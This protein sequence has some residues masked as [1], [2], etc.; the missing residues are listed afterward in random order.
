MA[1]IT[2]NEISKNYSYSVGTSS[3]ATVAMPITASWGPGYFNPDD[4]S[5]ECKEVDID[6]DW[7]IEN[8]SDMLDRTVWQRFPA[9]QAGLESFVSTYRG[10][11]PNFRL[12]QD[13]SYQMAITLLT[14]G[15]DVLVC[16]LSPGARAESQFVYRNN[17]QG[18][19]ECDAKVT[20]KAKYPG[21]FGNNLRV[22]I[23]NVGFNSVDANG[24]H[25]FS[26][27][28]NMLVYIVDGSGI[29]TPVENK[30]FVFDINNADDNLQHWREVESNYVTLSVTGN[31]IDFTST[32]ETDKH[33]KIIEKR[34]GVKLIDGSDNNRNST[35]E[36]LSQTK[37]F[38]V[39]DGGTD[40]NEAIEDGLTN[41]DSIKEKLI[42]E[43][44]KWANKRYRP[45]ADG[46]IEYINTGFKYAEIERNYLL[47]FD[48]LLGNADDVVQSVAEY[49][50]IPES[51]PRYATLKK[52]IGSTDTI[53]EMDL[54]KARVIHFREWI[55]THLVGLM[56]RD[57][58]YEGVY[59]LLKD[60]LAYNPNRIIASGWDDQD[61]CYM[62]G[63][64]D[65]NILCQQA[66][67]LRTT[68]PLHRKLMDTA[69]YS[70]CATSLLDIPR[71]CDKKFVYNNVDADESQLMGDNI[72]GYAQML[73]RYV[74]DNYDFTS[75]VNLYHTHSAL[76]VPWG[77]Y[78]FAT[79]NRQTIAPPSFL[80]VMIQ[81]AML[82]NQSLQYE[83][84][85]PSDRHHN[86][87][88]GKMDYDIPDKLLRVWQT[89]EGVAVNCITPM[90][91]LGT[92]L[93]GNSTLFE[94]PPATY[95]A[96]ANLSTRYLVNAIEDVIFRVGISITFQYSN[97]DA[98][99]TFVAGL[100]PIL[101][102]MKNAG[103]ITDYY[104][105]MGLDIR[106]EDLVNYNSVVGKVYICPAGVV[107]DISVDLICLPPNTS[108][109][110]Y[111]V[112]V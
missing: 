49:M 46:E 50:G 61:F 57:G 24:D 3:F 27:Y 43:A 65:T 93:W 56:T 87:K 48:Y 89:I 2:I 110:Q 36:I 16:R 55:Y 102:T 86:L 47:V 104:V 34:S 92:T 9:S 1:T 66:W 41:I 53:Q 8:H 82:L 45:Y 71:S 74:P 69:Y 107:N 6:K 94:T 97:N 26:Y 90:P 79:L 60:R 4:Y 85:L 23:K 10:P 68:S 109:D 33:G 5:S 67:G 100:L 7:D 11:I 80:A 96:L 13:Y 30:S 25:L 44:K 95:Q 19:P 52:L 112:E 12:A 84:L 38:V 98:F 32:Y 64:D 88:I 28:W 91:D 75:D 20:V 59:D 101:D 103:A 111:R 106:G 105:K 39:L 99:S 76:F 81:R 29:K 54:A 77:R 40:F 78:Q 22:D 73:A 51:D 72:P 62:L 35:G 17:K 15:Y 14:A 58:K 63:V 83:W 108:L 70:R 18:V 37:G 42:T 21:S 31:A